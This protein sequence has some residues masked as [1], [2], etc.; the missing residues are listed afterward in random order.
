MFNVCRFEPCAY[1]CFQY[2]PFRQHC[3]FPI[4]LVGVTENRLEICVAVC[5]GPIYVT[6]LLTLDLYSGFHASDNVVRLARVFGA[7]SRC[8]RDLKDYY[9]SVRISTSQR[10]SCLFPNATPIND[11]P[12]LPTGSSFHGQ[13]N[14]SQIM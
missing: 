12:N 7:L 3:N 2:K 4:V 10:L 5:V 6:K 9:T 11:Y 13:G 14:R 1:F 8:R